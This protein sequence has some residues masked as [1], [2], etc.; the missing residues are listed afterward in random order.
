MTTPRIEA[1][2]AELAA[3]LSEAIS[4]QAPTA[5]VRPKLLDI[6]TACAALGGL[7]RAKFYKMLASGD[8]P[9]TIKIGKR[10]MVVEASLAEFVGA[11]R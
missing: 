5:G 10:R 2:V 3:A 8:G 1:A 11:A 6:P 9:R 4:T 7:S